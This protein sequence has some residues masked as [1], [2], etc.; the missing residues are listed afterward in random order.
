MVSSAC[1]AHPA[2]PA[3]PP[4]ACRGRSSCRDTA[5]ASAGLPDTLRQDAS[6]G[7]CRWCS[8]RQNGTPADCWRRMKS[9]AAATVSSSIVSI[10]FLVGGPVSSM[11][12]LPTRPKRPSSVG[13]SSSVA[14][15]GSPPARPE[16]LP[17]VVAGWWPV[18]QL[19][20]SSAFVGYRL[21][22][23]RRSRARSGGTRSC[24]G[25]SC[26]T[27]RLHGPRL[28]T[29]QRSS[30]PRRAARH[31]R[32]GPRP[33][34]GPSEHALAGDERRPPGGTTLLAVGVGE[35]HALGGDPVD[36]GCPVARISPSL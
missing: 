26:R 2:G 29:A 1:R 33:C 23:T 28:R 11:R 21:P 7:A 25:G 31:R 30:D 14:A 5:T 34:S 24:R 22:R 3:V 20:S 19:G 36:V 8:S 27:A 10:R 4:R 17:E 18:Q 32:R 6:S 15:G 9:L 16:P 13:S 12:C 35:P